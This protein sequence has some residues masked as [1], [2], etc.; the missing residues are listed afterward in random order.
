[1]FTKAIKLPFKLAGI[2]VYLDFSFLLILPLIAWMIGSRISTWTQL[3]HIPHAASLSVGATPYILG[4]IAAVGLFIC[5]VLHE[6]GHAITARAFGIRTRSITLWFLGGVARLEGMP[7]QR[8][9][10]AI[11]GIMGP[12]VSFSLAFLFLIPL[13]FIP[14]AP[15]FVFVLAYLATTNFTL[16]IFNLIPAIPLDG[17]RVLRSLLA[18]AMSYTTATR[19]AATVSKILAIALGLFALFTG[20][21][22][23]VIIAVFVYLAGSSET[24]ATVVEDLL[25][26]DRVSD[27]M[28][29]EIHGLSPDATV[30]AAA[31]AMIQ[32]RRSTLPVMD[33]A[34]TLLGV[35]TLDQLANVAAT[36]PVSQVMSRDIPAVSAADDAATAFR[37]MSES[38]LDAL[39]VIDTA[40]HFLG[41]IT[42]A[43]L[44]TLL[45][46][47]S[48]AIP[49]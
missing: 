24:R 41:L 19:I 17:G 38:G 32:E 30:E 34:G 26:H 14:L 31:H 22:F 12:V 48:R 13:F 36:T 44:A 23:L 29:P 39:P 47:R 9:A 33:A 40:R 16:A 7:R 11:V 42:A 6:L 4:L 49:A 25:H 35:V 8:G 37:R 46:I 3:W 45:Q 10:E 27:I 15:A 20:Q 1:M 21:L 28:N 5:V 43:D 2:P 18:M